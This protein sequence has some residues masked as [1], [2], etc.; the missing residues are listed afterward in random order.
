MLSPLLSSKLTN[1]LRDSIGITVG[2]KG[3]DFLWQLKYTKE[4]SVL[5][6]LV[7]RL[8]EKLIRTL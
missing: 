5:Q 8:R 1:S 2:C 7:D 4:L 3:T 6:S